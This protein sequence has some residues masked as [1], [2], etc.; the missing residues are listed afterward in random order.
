MPDL[1]SLR[2]NM[3]SSVR[4]ATVA[5][6][7]ATPFSARMQPPSRHFQHKTASR[8]PARARYRAGGGLRP[9]V[10]PRGG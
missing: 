10:S 5:G 1:A 3:A 8:F 6:R 7:P 2:A 9:S 4:A